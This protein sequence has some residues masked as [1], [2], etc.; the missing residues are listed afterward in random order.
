MVDPPRQVSNNIDQSFA[1]PIDDLLKV[2]LI[3]S[4]PIYPER[5]PMRATL[6]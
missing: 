2:L 6:R 5:E 1:D 3:H 4:D